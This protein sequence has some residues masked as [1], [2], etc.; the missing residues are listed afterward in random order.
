[1]SA[2]I[3]P[4]A[5]PKGEKKLCEICQKPAKLQC[6]KCLVTFYCNLDHQQA[7]WTSIHE[8][9]CP[10]LVSINTPVPSGTLSDQNHHHKE[11]LKKQKCLIE[12]A[13]LEARKWVSMKRFQ[14]VLPAALLFQHWIMRVYGSCTVELVPAYLL[15]AQANIGIGSLSQ[16]QEY[17]S[18]AEWIV[19]KTADCSHTVL[20]QLHRTLGRLHA[21][22][23]KQASALTHFANDVYYAIEMFGLD[24]IVTSGGYFLMADVFLKQNKP[25]IAHSLYTE[26]AG[27]WH[28]HLCK[29]MDGISQSATQPDECFNEVQCV[30]ADQM[31]SCILEFEEQCVKPRPEQLTMLAHSLAMLWLLRDNYTKALEYGKKAEVLIQGVKEQNRLRESIHNL[32]QHAEKNMNE[33][34]NLHTADCNT[35]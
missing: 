18:K 28:T 27:S 24:S 14:D 34:A 6:T 3:Y 7:D 17:L 26:V 4:L 21:A 16:A 8:K 35:H 10:L 25:D 29:L 32:L 30:E 11:T 22:M 20:H 33:T 19:M 9:A 1:M 2:S 15:L 23:G 13:H 5:N 31:L 12:M